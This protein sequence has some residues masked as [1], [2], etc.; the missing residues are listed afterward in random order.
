MLF[1]IICMHSETK[2]TSRR[3]ATLV[4]TAV[5]ISGA[6]AAWS[7]GAVL[8]DMLDL[9]HTPGP[10]S[11]EELVIAVSA[12]M[13]LLLLVWV[14]LG[15]L[16]SVAATMPGPLGALSRT[17]RDTI[18]PQT[19]RRC[20][21]VLLGVAVMSSCG[22]SSAV[23][24]PLSARPD[25][26][27]NAQESSSAPAPAWGETADPP[28]PPPSLPAGPAPEWTPPVTRA[29]PSVTLTAPRAQVPDHGEV[30]VRRGDTLWDLAAAYLAPEATDAEVATEWQRWYVA[31]RDV[32]GAD[33][34]HILPGQ[35]LLIPA[36]SEAAPAGT[37]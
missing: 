18:A 7:L 34:D 21:G 29:L 11:V 4:S 2:G 19:V 14:A 9:F 22:P 30:T 23:A 13:A 37:R 32:I 8:R 1:S 25:A 20:A 3:R 24:S 17:V 15:L 26:P 12:A 6:A 5:A 35:V 36:P 16:A 10:T 31:N 33:P 27:S 28:P